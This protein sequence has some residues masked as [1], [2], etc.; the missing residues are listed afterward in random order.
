MLGRT[1]STGVRIALVV[2]VVVVLAG[3]DWNQLGGFGPAGTNFNPSEPALTAASVAHW[4]T[5]WSKPCACSSS[6]PLIVDG[7]V[8]IVD[9]YTGDTPFALTL[10]AYDAADGYTQ[11]SAPLG[12]SS[13]GGVLAAV[14]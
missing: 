7:T 4:T 14:A 11:W 8:Y 13:F 10:R 9:G 5:G 1:R 6:R 12:A 2:L 3:C